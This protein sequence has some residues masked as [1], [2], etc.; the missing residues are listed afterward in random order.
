MCSGQPRRRQSPD[1]NDWSEEAGG[2]RYIVDLLKQV[3]TV[4][5]E[6]MKLVRM[7]PPPQAC[8]VLPV[9]CAAEDDR[10][11]GQLDAVSP[12]ARV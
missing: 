7:L 12:V 8:A 10:P 3:V 5:A 2:P 6:T 9:R 11:V 4:S 1:P